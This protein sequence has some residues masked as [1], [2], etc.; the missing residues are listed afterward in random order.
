MAAQLILDFDALDLSQTIVERSE[1]Y[2]TLKQRGRFELLDGVLHHD[3]EGN[4]IVGYAKVEHGAWWAEDHIPGRPLFPGALM[5][6]AGAQLASF[7]FARRAAENADKFVGFGGLNGTRFRRIVEP[8]CRMILAA[9]SL[10]VRSRMFT[11]E[12]QAYVDRELVFHT[13][14][15]GVIV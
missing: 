9:K 15:I 13:E 3:I 14:V 2:E 10:R 12:V 8:D 5:I 4:L 6:E 7:D 11:Y 1:L